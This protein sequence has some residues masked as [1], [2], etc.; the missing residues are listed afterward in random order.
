MENTFNTINRILF[1]SLSWF[2]LKAIPLSCP[3]LT[4]GKPRPQ[5]DEVK[6]QQVA[7]LGFSVWANLSLEPEP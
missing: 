6:H 7:G 2:V 3:H 1:Q 4:D 5:E